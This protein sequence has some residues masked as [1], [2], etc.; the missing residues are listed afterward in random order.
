MRTFYD[1]YHFSKP[2]QEFVYNPT[3]AL[4]FLKYFQQDCTPFTSKIGPEKFFSGI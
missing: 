2:A 4:Y 3:L 1:G